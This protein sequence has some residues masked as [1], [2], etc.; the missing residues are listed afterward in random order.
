[1]HFLSTDEE[2]VMEETRKHKNHYFPISKKYQAKNSTK[3]EESG[4]TNSDTTTYN[5][6]NPVNFLF[7]N[8]NDFDDDD[9]DA[10]DT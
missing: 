1:M 6:E 2:Y 10:D 7:S 4:T 3:G 5:T 8:E 9:D